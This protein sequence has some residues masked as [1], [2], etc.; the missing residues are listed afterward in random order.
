MDNK[1]NLIRSLDN[2][3]IE[4]LRAALEL[5][6]QDVAS[7]EDLA[8][9]IVALNKKI[10]STAASNHEE[11]S[12][13]ERS[14][15][16]LSGLVRDIEALDAEISAIKKKP[17]EWGTKEE[18]AK[19]IEEKLPE[20][21]DLDPLYE[22]LKQVEAKIKPFP[23]QEV[24]PE[25]WKEFDAIEDEIEKLKKEISKKNGNSYSL[26]PDRGFSGRLDTWKNGSG[27][28]MGT[29]TVSPTAPE[30]PAVNDLWCDS[31]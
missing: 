12:R 4:K 6:N 11:I 24:P 17:R 30:N 9:V 27:Q 8:K 1:Q 21:A 25:V 5:A 3:K 26:F 22:K 13:L 23:K 18:V 20:P 19:L 2:K 31:S 29:L 7:L 28:T 14:V 10:Q 15:K 16:S